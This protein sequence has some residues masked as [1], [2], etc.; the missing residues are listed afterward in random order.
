MFKVRTQFSAHNL[1]QTEHRMYPS[2]RV[3][4]VNTEHTQNHTKNTYTRKKRARG[5]ERGN[6]RDTVTVD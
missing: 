1:N 5:R 6:K 2:S 4:I 3:K